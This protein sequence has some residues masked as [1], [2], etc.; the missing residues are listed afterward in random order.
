VLRPSPA[1]RQLVEEFERSLF[2][3]VVNDTAAAQGAS[4]ASSRSKSPTSSSPS[5]QLTA[6]PQSYVVI[7]LRAFGPSCHV[8]VKRALERQRQTITAAQLSGREVETKDL[9][10][11]STEYVDAAIAAHARSIEN[12]AGS[13][14]TSSPGKTS[15]S[16]GRE[17]LKSRISDVRTWPVVL[18]HDGEDEARAAAIVSRYGARIYRGPL[19]PFVDLLLMVRAG[20]FIGNPASSFSTNAA[21]VRYAVAAAKTRAGTGETA[22]IPGNSAH[23]Y[24]ATNLRCGGAPGSDPAQC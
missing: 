16:R 23:F 14:S 24:P 21:R 10:G 13:D 22:G 2:A 9:C 8:R 4:T 6:V 19:A 17:V 11:M 18:A 5:S 20:L 7:H 12:S 3:P 15:S 1:L